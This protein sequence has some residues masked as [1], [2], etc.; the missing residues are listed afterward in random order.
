[1]L[2][3]ASRPLEAHQ[4]VQ[5]GFLIEERKGLNASG[6]ARA[7]ALDWADPG[8]STMDKGEKLYILGHG[9]TKQIG[10]ATKKDQQWDAGAIAKK[11]TAK[12]T[13]I[14][15]HIKSIKLMSC[16]AGVGTMT[17]TNEA[18]CV[19][20]ARYL[21]ELSGGKLTVQISAITGS[22]VLTR[23]NKDVKGDR[24]VLRAIA[25]DIDFKSQKTLFLKELSEKHT[26]EFDELNKMSEWED[27]VLRKTYA[28]DTEPS[29][30]EA[31]K[32]CYERFKLAYALGFKYTTPGVL[33]AKA[34]GKLVVKHDGKE[35][36]RIVK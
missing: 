2:C 16:H 10:G 6:K 32:V 11:L 27:N 29:I 28:G 26:K 25:S 14:P 1:M 34:P 13:G 9:N 30:L 18:F 22:S 36:Q 24:V 15:D 4:L 5:G 23:E 17:G 7:C 19:T 3:F 33:K 31:I 35:V 12:D 20:L 21:H 8:F